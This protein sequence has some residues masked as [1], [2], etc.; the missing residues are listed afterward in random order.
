[1]FFNPTL[2][3]IEESESLPLPEVI[4]GNDDADWAAWGDSVAFQESQFLP[5]VTLVESKFIDPFTLV[6]KKGA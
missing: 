6:S 3:M 1:M 4:E 5:Q 2:N